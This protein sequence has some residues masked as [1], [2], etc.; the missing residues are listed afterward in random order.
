MH[1]SLRWALQ[2]GALCATIL[3]MLSFVHPSERV[4][5][6]FA[7][8]PLQTCRATPPYKN[9]GRAAWSSWEPS[10]AIVSHTTLDNKEVFGGLAART[11][12]S[13]QMLISGPATGPSI[14]RL[15]V[16]QRI[17]ESTDFLIVER[18]ERRAVWVQHFLCLRCS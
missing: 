10:T 1:A 16:P 7:S 11:Y 14:K 8:R 4:T 6:A 9:R 18:H 5:P 13:L 12:L 3:S 2:E 15:G 17:P